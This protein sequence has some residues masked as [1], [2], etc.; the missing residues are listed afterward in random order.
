MRLFVLLMYHNL[1]IF[2]ISTEE[3]SRRYAIH[4]FKQSLYSSL[5]ADF[6]A[7]SLKILLDLATTKGVSA[8]LSAFP[9]SEHR[10]TT[11]HNAMAFYVNHYGWPLH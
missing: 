3:L 8:R 5:H 4:L 7:Y 11:F 10:F 2:N 1:I 6:Q 9:L